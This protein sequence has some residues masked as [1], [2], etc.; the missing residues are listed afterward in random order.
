[1]FG[2][3]RLENV[4]RESRDYSAQ[5]VIARLRTAVETF[6]KGTKQQDDLTAVVIKRKLDLPPTQL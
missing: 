4:I 6:C 3:A 5:E 2:M 1:Q